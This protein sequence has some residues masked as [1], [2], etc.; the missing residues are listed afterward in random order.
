M[1]DTLLLKDLTEADVR[2]AIREAMSPQPD[3]DRPI[4][5]RIDDFLASVDWSD[6]GG[7]L[8]PV[9]ALL[10]RLEHWATEYAEGDLARLDYLQRLTEVIR[11]GSAVGEDTPPYDAGS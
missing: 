3:F 4:L 11:S 5:D 2:S 8:T 6:G 9:A 10:G 1:S 7:V